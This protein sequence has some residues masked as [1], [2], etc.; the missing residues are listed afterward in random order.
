VRHLRPRQSLL[1]EHHRVEGEG[2]VKRANEVNPV[3]WKRQ[4]LVA[5]FTFCA[6]GAIAGVFFAWL[7]SPFRIATSHALSGE[8]ADAPSGNDSEEI[9][10][11][12]RRGDAQP[13]EISLIKNRPSAEGHGTEI[14]SVGSSGLLMT[15]D[16]ARE[17]SGRGSSP[18][19]T[20]RSR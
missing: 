20:S 8:W 3:R 19:R 7:D 12:V 5:G 15:A 11:E 14:R 18:I 13:F 1:R 16:E 4:N 17:V 6:V 9:I 2:E 10:F